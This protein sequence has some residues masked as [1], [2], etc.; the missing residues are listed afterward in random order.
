MRKLVLK[1]S[2]S[3]D[4][5][6]GGADGDVDWIFCRMDDKAAAW[7]VGII[8]Q[9]GIH[10]MGSRTFHDMI[11]YWPTSMEPYAP[12]MNEIPKAVFTRKGLVPGEMP[13]TQALQDASRRRDEQ[14]LKSVPASQAV[15][16]SWTGARVFSG[17]MALGIAELKSQPGKEIL[18]HGGASFA[19]G[20]IKTGMVDEYC[21]LVHPVALG[22]GLPIFSELEAPLD[23]KLV[24]LV[25]FPSG[26]VGKTFL[27]A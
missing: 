22:K 23:L 2:I 1:M 7:T 17:D 19:R 8:W 13:T 14:G 11:N 15:M 16:D 4:G 20:L 24:E 18:A 10:I 25:Q 5:F 27:P 12:P 6:V 21:L 9:A 26:A 3:L